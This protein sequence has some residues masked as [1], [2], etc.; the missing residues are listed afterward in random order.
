M[1]INYLQELFDHCILRNDTAH[2]RLLVNHPPTS[3]HFEE[4]VE[5]ANYRHNFTVGVS[6]DFEFL[7]S[8]QDAEVF[9][10]LAPRVFEDHAVY[11]IYGRALA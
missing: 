8:L 5:N 6:E 4:P 11:S 3:E 7:L 2:F 9:P 1:S 10:R